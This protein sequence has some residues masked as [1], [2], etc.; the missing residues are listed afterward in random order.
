VDNLITNGESMAKKKEKNLMTLNYGGQ[1]YKFELESLSPEGKAHYNRANEVAAEL[2]RFEQQVAEKKWLTGKYLSF[3]A[4]E[5][6][7]K[8]KDKK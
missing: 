3:I 2:L 5:L 7:D 6:D 8:D 4:A 1:E